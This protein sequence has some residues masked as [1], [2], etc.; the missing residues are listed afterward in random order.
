MEVKIIHTPGHSRGSICILVNGKYL[1][2]GDTIYNNSIGNTDI[3]TGS[4][5][6]IVASIKEKIQPLNDTII[7]CQGHGNMCTLKDIRGNIS[8]N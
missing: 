7:I 1:F 6:D 2:T 8:L 3:D 4:Y 5:D